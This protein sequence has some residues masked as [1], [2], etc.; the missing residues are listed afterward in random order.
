MQKYQPESVIIRFKELRITVG[1][2]GDKWNKFPNAQ[3]FE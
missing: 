1:I 3:A 2:L